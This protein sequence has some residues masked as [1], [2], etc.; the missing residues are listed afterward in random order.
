MECKIRLNLV[1]FAG[2]AY[3]SR[4]DM[5]FRFSGP[6]NLHAGMN[7]IALLSIAVGLP[8]SLSA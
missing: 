1:W 3:G 5:M 8:V 6:V 2:S 7:S 4:N